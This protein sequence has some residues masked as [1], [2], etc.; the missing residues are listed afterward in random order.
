MPSVRTDESSS[1]GDGAVVS[2]CMQGVRTDESSS[3]TEQPP[4]K[5]VRT[6]DTNEPAAHGSAGHAACPGTGTYAGMGA[7]AA[8]SRRAEDDEERSTK[9]GT[10]ILFPP[11]FLLPAVPPSQ[12]P[13]HLPT[14]FQPAPK[15]PLPTQ[16]Q[17]QQPHPML[18]QE[19][20]Q[21]GGSTFVDEL[22][23]LDAEMRALN[24]SIDQ[25]ATRFC[26]VRGD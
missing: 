15:P 2:T 19:P 25:V 26:E 22:A 8:A 13:P 10:R 24:A 9:G 1:W 18:Q 4:W 17:P 6:S 16:A 23:A 12:P 21:S 20:Q 3:Y 7:G 5:A 11:S 14:F